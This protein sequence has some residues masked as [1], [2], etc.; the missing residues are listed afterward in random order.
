MT[1]IGNRQKYDRIY[2]KKK[3]KQDSHKRHI[4]IPNNDSEHEDIIN[5]IKKIYISRIYE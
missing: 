4:L 3:K 2:N 1:D 5:D